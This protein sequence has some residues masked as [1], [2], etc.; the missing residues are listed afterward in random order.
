MCLF[1]GMSGERSLVTGLQT[2]LQANVD[3]MQRCSV[4][5]GPG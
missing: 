2:M 4:A 1:P 5:V 3:V